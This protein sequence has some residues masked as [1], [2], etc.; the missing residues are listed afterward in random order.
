M[1]NTWHKREENRKLTFRMR[2]NE[3]EID[4]ELIKNTDGL[5][6]M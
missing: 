4:F 3:T 1:S 5:F 2:E 6:K